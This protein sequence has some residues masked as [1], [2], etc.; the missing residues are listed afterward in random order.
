MASPGK[1]RAVALVISIALITW[2]AM[3]AI[4][5]RNSATLQR[6]VFAV[7]HAT[8]ADDGGSGTYAGLGYTVELE[9]R[10]DPER[11]PV[12]ESTEMRLL[13]RWVMPASI[14]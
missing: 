3:L 12:V 2:A 1:S 6:P 5:C 8:T 9:M 11:G 10:V 7:P 13:G 14:E 4:D